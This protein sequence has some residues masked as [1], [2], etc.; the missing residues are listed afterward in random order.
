MNIDMTLWGLAFLWGAVLGLFYF[1]G[2]WFT[3]KMMHQRE[4]PKLWLAFSYM[5]RLAGALAGFWLVVQKDAMAFIFTLVAFFAIRII[6][7]RTLKQK[8]D[9]KDHATQSR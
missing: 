9:G 5:V 8:S 2:L 7:T 1:G 6:L 3:L 4:R